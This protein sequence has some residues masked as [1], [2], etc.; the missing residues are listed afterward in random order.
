MGTVVV[1][2]AVLACSHQGQV[3]V[4][5]GDPRLTV[6]GAAV[7][8]SGKES[9]LDFP[10]GTLP[11][12][13][14]NQTTTQSPQPAPCITQAAASGLAVKLTVGGKPVLLATAGGPTKPALTPAVPGTWTVHAPGQSKL[15]AS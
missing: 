14:S 15:T 3:A 1:V 7:L 10:A 11:P 2:N 13:C 12:S 6:G 9:G 8:T 5:A 4:A